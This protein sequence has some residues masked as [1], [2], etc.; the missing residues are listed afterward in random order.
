MH[1]RRDSFPLLCYEAANG[2]PLLALDLAL[3][4][5]MLQPLIHRHPKLIND[6]YVVAA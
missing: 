4:W 6:R 1:H 2:D 3:R 5:L